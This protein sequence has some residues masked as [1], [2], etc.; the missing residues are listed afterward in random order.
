MSG[1]P[2]VP[3]G[4]VVIIGGGIVGLNAA[5]MALGLGARV[6]ILEI[7]GEQM[8][9]LDNLFGGEATTFAS[10]PHNLLLA[11]GRADVLIGAVLIPGYS[12]P[13]LVTR[14]MLGQQVGVGAT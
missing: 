7:S 10:N 1:V 8:R 5:R 11:M 3:P 4:D 12:A 13:Q 14:E 6:T 2:G 9:Y